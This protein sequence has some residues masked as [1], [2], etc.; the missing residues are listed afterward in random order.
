MQTLW[1]SIATLLL[2]GLSCSTLSAAPVVKRG[3]QVTIHP[4]RVTVL[5]EFSLTTESARELVGEGIADEGIADEGTVGEDSGEDLRYVLMERFRELA[6]REIEQRLRIAVDG[7]SLALRAT[8]ATLFPKHFVQL[9]CEYEA[10]LPAGITGGELTV[11]DGSFRGVAGDQQIAIRGKGG[12]EIVS[13]TVPL[14]LARAGRGPEFDASAQAR[15]LS[16]RA[17]ARFVVAQAADAEYAEHAAMEPSTASE[18]QSD[19]H[20]AG[21][22]PS[23]AIS[24]NV[25]IIAALVLVLIAAIVAVLFWT[26]RAR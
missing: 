18:P 25:I 13:S 2:T 16:R 9:A 12:V 19:E 6:E 20:S 26:N 10:P 1:R 7:V 21:D 5:C 22:V 4:E 23:S 3:L 11:S 17:S 8:E 15:E 14:I 24:L